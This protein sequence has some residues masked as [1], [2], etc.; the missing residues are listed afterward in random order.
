M[1]TAPTGA[2]REIHRG[3]PAAR[4][5]HRERTRTIRATPDIDD[6]AR[7]FAELYELRAAIRWRFESV[8]VEIDGLSAGD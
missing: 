1:R 7:G 3:V 5:E 8:K 6:F 4:R 2:A